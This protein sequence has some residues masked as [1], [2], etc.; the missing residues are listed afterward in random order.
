MATTTT[1]DLA[2][3]RLLDVP[4]AAEL[5]GINPRTVRRMFDERWLP[6]VKIGRRVFVWSDDLAHALEASTTPARRGGAR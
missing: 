4:A 1:P 2:A 5:L 3:R 6:V